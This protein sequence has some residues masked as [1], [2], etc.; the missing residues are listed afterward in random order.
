MKQ[1]RNLGL[2]AGVLLC[3]TAALLWA[4]NTN[5]NQ[6][7]Y[8][9]QKI[10]LNANGTYSAVN[11]LNNQGQ[12]A[13]W[14]DL[15]SNDNTRHPYVYS[16]GTMTDLGTFGGSGWNGVNGF[17]NL[18]QAAGYANYSNNLQHAFLYTGGG[19]IDLTPNSSSNSTAN[20]INDSGQVV[21]GY[22]DNNGYYHAFLYQ[23]GTFTDLDLNNA[24]RASLALG[25]NSSGQIYGQMHSNT[26]T[27]PQY[28][29]GF[30]YANGI[31]TTFLPPSSSGNSS[32]NGMNDAGQIVG[33]ACCAGLTY[34]FIYNI[35][36][37]GLTQLSGAGSSN[38]TAIA[39]NNNGQVVGYFVNPS[40]GQETGFIYSGGAYTYLYAFGVGANG[41]NR[42][43]PQTINILGQV[44]GR[45]IGTDEGF[46]PYV[47][48]NG[49][50]T[51]VNTLIDST[52]GVTLNKVSLINDLG[53][54]V[55]YDYNYAYLL[56][57][58]L[59][60]TSTHSGNFSTGQ[61]NATYL[62]TVTNSANAEQATSGTISVAETVPAGLTLVSMAGQGWNCASN[63]CTRTDSIGPGAS[64]PAITVTVNVA[65]GATSPQVNRASVSEGG[66]QLG[67]AI[68]STV[69]Q[70][71]GA[72]TVT[73]SAATAQ[74][75]TS[76]QNVT[77]NAT[78]STAGSAV[79][80]GTV[81]FTVTG[82]GS[83][84]S[85]T[86]TG[87]NASAV[88]TVNGGT[89]AG[90]YPIHAVYSGTTGIAGSSDA[91]KS[92][93]ISNAVPVI[94]WANPADMILGSALGSGQ[95][96]AT[97]NVPGSFT[98]TPPAGTVL[99]QGS[100]TLS[101][102]FTPNDS[103]DYSSTSATAIVNV[104]AGAGSGSGQPQ[105]VVTR[106]LSRNGSNNIVVLV[107]VTNTGS[108]PALAQGY[109]YVT[110]GACKLGSLTPSA[111]PTVPGLIAPGASAQSTITFPGSAGA[112]G[113]TVLLTINGTWFLNVGVGQATQGDG[114]S[115][116]YT[117][118]TV[119]P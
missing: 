8:T 20:G 2:L 87:G 22:T 5:T 52:L 18:G 19:L 28:N 44:G 84:T 79:N 95:L 54:L 61:Q 89:Q 62:L 46:H 78:V 115:F 102:T 80:G 98:Y 43:E 117:S 73:A 47:Y 71:L 25:I 63:T 81:S 4:S 39:I 42:N 112:S 103:T 3:A 37:A 24:T 88:L 119:L 60:V 41:D 9:V 14:A 15:Y 34:P 10:M 33:A 1:F 113:A 105:F 111:G 93:T 68:D 64:Y 107:T 106:T 13:G 109:P 51:D 101:V 108:Q 21:G 76:S 35:N 70:S 57:P 30:Y 23:N 56:T 92:L 97:A 72:S 12:A 55:A 6:V 58:V 16:G 83:V 94:T 26:G 32:I 66:I 77:L 104:V 118:R 11:V 91:T 7:M 116:G 29:G 59:N 50:M 110:L 17:N 65:G 69:I 85:G 82:I 114:G 100:N 67:D 96:D 31:F 74:Y 75:S 36:T 86:V 27:P 90:S 45:A 48:S 53:Q 38:G 49:V 99:P 40:N